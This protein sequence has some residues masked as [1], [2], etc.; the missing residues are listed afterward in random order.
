MDQR[1]NVCCG[2][3][4]AFDMLSKN[5]LG[6]GKAETEGKNGAIRFLMKS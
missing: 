1:V 6:D 4:R 2:N 5:P 3:G